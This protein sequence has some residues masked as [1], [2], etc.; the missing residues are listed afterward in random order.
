MPGTQAHDA[1]GS[2]QW[3]G[4]ES[5][6]FRLESSSKVTWSPGSQ[7]W[8]L[9]WCQLVMGFPLITNKLRKSISM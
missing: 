9:G 7:T 8:G 1:V 6:Q 3:A 5:E 2:V 4:L